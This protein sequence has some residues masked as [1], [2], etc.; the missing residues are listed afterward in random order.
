MRDQQNKLIL[1]MHLHVEQKKVIFFLQI[2]TML[3]DYGLT[4][5]EQKDPSKVFSLLTKMYS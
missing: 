1:C 5:Q 3:G 2:E 4:L